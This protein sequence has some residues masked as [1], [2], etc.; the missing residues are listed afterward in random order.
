MNYILQLR[1]FFEF[2][3]TNKLSAKA[4]AL[5][6]LIFAIANTEYFD[7]VKITAQRIKN[8]LHICMRDVYKL[9]QELIEN[10]LILY[11]NGKYQICALYDTL[12]TQN[13]ALYDTKDEKKCALYDTKSAHIKIKQITN[14]RKYIKENKKQEFEQRTYTKKE[15]DSIFSKLENVKWI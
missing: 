6:Y 10:E 1:C 4:Q 3:S 15:F 12:S 9:R 8:T 2:I 11:D 7:P 5:Y 14:K 13:C